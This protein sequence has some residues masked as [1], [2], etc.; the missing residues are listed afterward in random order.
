MNIKT[1]LILAATAVSLLSTPA[2]AFRSVNAGGDS[3]YAIPPNERGHGGMHYGRTKAYPPYAF[4]HVSRRA[5]Q[6][7]HRVRP[8]HP[9]R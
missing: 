3:A 2:F 5:T 8:S 9:R 1:K 6:R 7:Q 4:G